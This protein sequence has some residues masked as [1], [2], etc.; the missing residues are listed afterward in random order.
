MNEFIEY[1]INNNLGDYQENGYTS[2]IVRT[3]TSSPY[4]YLK[5]FEEI[6]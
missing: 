4:G 6:F 3:F 5:Y 2:N 1:F